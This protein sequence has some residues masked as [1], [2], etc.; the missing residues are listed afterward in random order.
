M[1]DL[2][3]LLIVVDTR[4]SLHNTQDN[5]LQGVSGHSHHHLV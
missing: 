1:S 4:E 3:Q 2:F 5:A